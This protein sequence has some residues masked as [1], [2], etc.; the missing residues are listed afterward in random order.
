MLPTMRQLYNFLLL[1]FG[2]ARRL[3]FPE[4]KEFLEHIAPKFATGT[5]VKDAAEILEL[6]ESDPGR[7]EQVVARSI[8]GLAKLNI[9]I[10]P[11]LPEVLNRLSKPDTGRLAV[12]VLK[13]LC[14]EQS[15]ACDAKFEFGANAVRTA[16][17]LGF[18]HDSA[19]SLQHRNW[20]SYSQEGEDLVLLRLFAKQSEGFYVDV[21]AHHPYRFSNTAALYSKGWS[22]INIE[23]DPDGFEL[24]RVSRTRDNNL[25]TAVLTGQASQ[26]EARYFRF[27]EPAL[28]TFD[29]SYAEEMKTLGHVIKEVVDLPFRSL[30]S[31][32]EEHR[33]EGP[34]DLMSVDCE[35]MDLEVLSSNDWSRWR[36]RYVIVEALRNPSASLFDNPIVDFMHEKKYQVYLIL[37]NSWIFEEKK[38]SL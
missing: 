12:G 5:S 9:L 38:E 4:C 17:D 19:M 22:G 3:S 26:R 34:I 31:I 14:G 10:N 33:P 36:P 29:E 30:S 7:S 2:L 11:D 25:N 24:L 16:K 20:Y 21:G 8:R 6:L 23:P 15:T 32:F 27:L 1:T 37:Y 35:G 28:N 18:L 13:D